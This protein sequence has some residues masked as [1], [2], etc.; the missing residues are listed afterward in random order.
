MQSLIDA[1]IKSYSEITFCIYYLLRY[2][3]C[4]SLQALSLIMKWMTFLHLM[5]STVMD[6]LL[7]RLIIICDFYLS[8]NPYVHHIALSVHCVGIGDAGATVQLV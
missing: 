3:P 5:L 6:F 4:Y 8:I 2:S 7:T 1:K